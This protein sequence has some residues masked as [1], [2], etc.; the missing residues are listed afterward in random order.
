MVRPLELPDL[1]PPAAARAP[2][3]A[4][5]ARRWGL[6]LVAGWLVQAGLR[7]WLSQAQ[8]VPLATPDESAYLI[9]ARVLAGG[10]PANFS[11]STLYPAGY[12]LLITPVYWFT[13]DPATVY[14]AVL[15]GI[16]APISALVMP[17]GYVACRRLGLERPT[18]FGV[19]M[20]AAL[21]PAA[22]FYSQYAMTDAIYPVLVLAWLLAVHSWLTARSI[23]GQYCA[24]AGSALL[25]GYSYAVH[26]RG[27]VMIAGYVLVGVF[28]AGQRL[29]PRRTALA[30][31]A[32]LGLP[33][34]AA[35][36]L[37]R[38]LS[39][40]MYPS[41]PRTLAG[42][43]LIRLHSTHGVIF[44]LEMAAGQLW[45]FVVDGWGVTGLGLSAAVFVIVQRTARTD[46]RIMAA[47]GVGVTLVTAVVSPA[48]LPPTQPQA[49]ASGR[50]LDGMVVAF[51]LVG[52]AVLL[53]SAPRQ[54]VVYA[55]CVVPPT[56]L[57]AIVVLAYTGGSVPTSGFGAAFVFAEP[58]V[59]TQNWTQASVLLATAVALGLLAAA[60][61]VVVF[62]SRTSWA[63]RGQVVLLTGLG[64]VSLVAT[65]QMTSHISQANTPGQE[66]NITAVVTGTGLEPG[67]HLA[68]GTGLS[69][70]TWMPQAYEVWWA[71]LEF[72]ST[73][74]QP[75]PANATV[76]EV[77]WSGRQPAAA[78]WPQ[79]P[80][81]WRIAVEDQV[82]G[83]VAWRR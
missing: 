69:W 77:A 73:G 10:V 46:A 14:R 22:L 43:A 68:I 51:F 78:S 72:F 50:Y 31:A 32:A 64:A 16:N 52:A 20:V 48:A 11:Y 83:W 24:A 37:N 28:V 9:A 4:G 59:L 21:L 2:I 30:A 17:L 33:L 1:A 81:G 54:V 40:V 62:A 57:A 74:S 65:L 8:M 66:R 36:L 18:A 38:H 23:G 75:P 27:A 26:S 39:S 45:R 5:R 3:S 70:Q 25:A 7:A 12:P 49:W 15:L 34:G 63:Q 42:E 19:A 79:A 47:L 6:L 55:A 41:G 80:A 71:P 60:V 35:H 56:L 67:Q 29:V 44:V 82:D 13:H 53:R 61:G 58:A 76:V